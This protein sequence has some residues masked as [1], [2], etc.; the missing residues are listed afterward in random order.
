MKMGSESSKG[1]KSKNSE[2]GDQTTEPKTALSK[3]RLREIKQR[4]EKAWD[5]G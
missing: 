5:S 2:S 4:I 1:G 3:E